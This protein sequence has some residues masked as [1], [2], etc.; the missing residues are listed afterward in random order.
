MTGFD[1]RRPHHWIATG[2]GSGL[3]P[4]APG[5][6]GTLAAIPPYLLLAHLPLGLYLAMLALVS[7]I[8]VWACGRMAS[9]LGDDDPA[10]VVW[11]EF[12]GYWVAMAGAP[13]GW[14]WILAG[15][16][17]FRLFDI[18]KPWPLSAAERL[19][20]AGVGIMLDDLLAGALSWATLWLAA[21]WLG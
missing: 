9:D 6:V 19:R 10:C 4:R 8:G 17:V 3:A 13:A 15:F 5:T 1:P 12:A 7:A 20:P 18:W 21:L 16:A 11:D 14:Q 2:L